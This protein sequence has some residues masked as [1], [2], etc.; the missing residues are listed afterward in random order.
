MPR[1]GNLVGSYKLWDPV[2]GLIRFVTSEEELRAAHLCGRLWS[3]KLVCQFTAVLDALDSTN[4]CD[5][6]TNE[7]YHEMELLFDLVGVF[8]L[9][10][11]LFELQ[12]HSALSD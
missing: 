7:I 1:R 10:V 3:G 8:K 9:E 6:I 4:I 5:M 11:L 12:L 2:N